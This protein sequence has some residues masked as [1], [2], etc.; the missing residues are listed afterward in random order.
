MLGFG[1]LYFIV[2]REISRLGKRRMLLIEVIMQ[3]LVSVVGVG[4]R[5]G[6]GLVCITMGGIRRFQMLDDELLMNN[7]SFVMSC[8]GRGLELVES[9]EMRVRQLVMR[10]P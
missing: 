9:H 8:V 7:F 10:L 6:E 3:A 2:S 4:V 1:L 5:H